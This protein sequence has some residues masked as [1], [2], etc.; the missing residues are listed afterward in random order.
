MKQVIL[1]INNFHD[2][3]QF[4]RNFSLSSDVPSDSIPSSLARVLS[5]NKAVRR[6]R[7]RHDKRDSEAVRVHS[8]LL[9]YGEVT[10]VVSSTAG[11][12]QRRG[13]ASGAVSADGKGLLL[14]LDGDPTASELV[15]KP[16]S[17]LNAFERKLAQVINYH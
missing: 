15:S 6:F 1:L 9:E 17:E 8:C 16:A 3:L 11:S 2:T 10:A 7:R 5:R 4:S 12:A 13:S 14:Q